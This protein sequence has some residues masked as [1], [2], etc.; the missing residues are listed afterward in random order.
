[1]EVATPEGVRW[2][3]DDFQDLAGEGETY[4]YRVLL[5]SA[6]LPDGEIHIRFTRFHRSTS[7]EV[8]TEEFR[9]TLK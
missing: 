9:F 6:A 8:H 3:E 1:M 5:N 4:R 2:H 7:E